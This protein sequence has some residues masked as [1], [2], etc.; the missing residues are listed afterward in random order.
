L[1][2]SASQYSAR[3]SHLAQCQ[4]YNSFLPLGSPQ[5]TRQTFDRRRESPD[6]VAAVAFLVSRAASFV[7]GKVMIV[8]GGE[9]RV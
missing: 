8:E 1:S 9:F 4:A 2:A 7:T 6:V 5:I 3:V